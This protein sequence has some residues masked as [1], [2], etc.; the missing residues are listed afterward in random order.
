MSCYCGYK[1]PSHPNSETVNSHVSRLKKRGSSKIA[2]FFN[3]ESEST[4]SYIRSVKW[5][6]GCSEAGD[7][8]IYQK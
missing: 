4:V 5:L 3:Q 7:H 6:S 1:G 8:E 2:S